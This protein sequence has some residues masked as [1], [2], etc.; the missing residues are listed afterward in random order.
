MV[1]VLRT[2]PPGV[3]Y[4][5]QNLAVPSDRLVGRLNFSIWKPVCQCTDRLQ[6]KTL[7]YPLFQVAASTR[8]ILLE[9]KGCELAQSILPVNAHLLE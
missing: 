3:T 6:Q 2:D 8:Q 1:E 7:V 4:I 5:K 9:L